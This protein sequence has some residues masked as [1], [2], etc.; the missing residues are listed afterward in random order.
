MKYTAKDIS[1][2]VSG[3]IVGDPD[4]IINKPAK[5]EEGEKGSITFLSN[6]KYEQYAYTTR[7]SAIL[8]SKEFQPA[9][10]IKSTLI[11]VDNVYQAVGDL[12]KHFDKKNHFFSGISDQAHV[13]NPEL[14]GLN[15][16]IASFAYLDKGVKIGRNVTI[17]PHAYI[18]ANS[19]IG[20]N[21]IIHSGV[22]IYQDSQIGMN[23]VLH[24]NCVIGSDGFG[25]VPDE[26]GQFHKI[27]QIGNVILEDSVEIGA[28]TVV[29]RATM[30]ST[31]IRSGAKL[32][33]LIQIA[34]NAEVG[35]HSVIAAQSGIAGSSKIGAKSKIGGQVGVAGHLSIAEG[36]QIQ[37]QSGI[38]S[39]IK[40][41]NKKWYGSPAISYNKF[42]RSYAIFRKLPDLWNKI[43]KIEKQINQNSFN[44]KS[45]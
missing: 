44:Q 32:D 14:I 36:S 25:F 42:L 38:A 1:L 28:N 9:Q 15:S 27:N 8:V 13:S 21:T 35:E 22:K 16:N 6:P 43:A 41:K 20:D 24:S 34:H 39:S 29:D 10:P 19:S 37:A 2:L 30:G 23:C 7:A 26:S 4:I 45:D 12:L 31:I 18:G 17:Y 5:I 3:I 11:K 33:N 40:D